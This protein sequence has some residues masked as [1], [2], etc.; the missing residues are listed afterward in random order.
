MCVFTNAL[1]LKCF[2]FNIM[3]ASCEHFQVAAV[4]VAEKHQEFQSILALEAYN[5]YIVLSSF[6]VTFRD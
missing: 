6:F 1:Y 3:R 5:E 4:Q 2:I